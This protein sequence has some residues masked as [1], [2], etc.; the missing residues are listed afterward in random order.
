MKKILEFAE[1]QDCLFRQLKF[2]FKYGFP[3]F[4]FKWF[5]E[6]VFLTQIKH[7]I[8][9]VSLLSFARTLFLDGLKSSLTLFSL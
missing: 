6:L 8:L 9:F 4:V 2:F 7:P 3:Y 5:L 1:T